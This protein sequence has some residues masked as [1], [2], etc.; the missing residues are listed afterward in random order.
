MANSADPDQAI[1]HLSLHFAHTFLCPSNKKNSGLS[2]YDK[3]K[4]D[5][6]EYCTYKSGRL[7]LMFATSNKISLFWQLWN[8]HI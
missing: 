6:I 2:M 5:P 1:P 3:F 4:I 7:K 8:F